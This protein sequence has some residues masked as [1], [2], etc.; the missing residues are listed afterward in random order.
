MSK[1]WD[2]L[3]SGFSQRKEAS[4]ARREV[5]RELVA[6][7]EEQIQLIMTLVR[8]VATER[9]AA[10]QASSGLTID[11]QWPSHPPIN[12]DPDG[13]FMSFMCLRMP[14]R[15]VHLYSHRV[16]TEEPLIHFVVAGPEG[17]DRQRKR[18]LSKP[19]C[20][21]EKRDGGGFLLRGVGGGG[22]LG[23]LDGGRIVSVDDLA[24]RAFELLLDDV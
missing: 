3:F 12:I 2:A 24:F 7:Y 13:P 18:L 20:R 8:E 9:A 4:A 11:V 17:A 1:N 5:S 16:G 19:G 14:E 21:L 10:F 15:E 23:G 22:G 6:W